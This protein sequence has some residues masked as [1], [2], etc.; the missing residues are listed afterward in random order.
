MFLN[1]VS[2]SSG[3]RWLYFIQP[4]MAQRRSSVRC[5]RWNLVLT[6]AS[7]ECIHKPKDA[8][9]ASWYRSVWQHCSEVMAASST[10]ILFIFT[11]K[12]KQK[13]T[14]L[15]WQMSSLNVKGA[16]LSTSWRPE[17]WTTA[18]NLIKTCKSKRQKEIIICMKKKWSLY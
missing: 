6:P 2:A 13:N 10:L 9:P 14:S 8:T 7:I 5:R 1:L 15:K 12:Q 16:L 18:V 17:A 4:R 3:C 11:G